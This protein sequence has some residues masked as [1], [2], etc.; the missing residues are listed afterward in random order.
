MS[1][2]AWPN[3]IFVRPFSICLLV[4]PAGLPVPGD[5]GDRLVIKTHH[6]SQKKELQGQSN[7]ID[8]NQS[9]GEQRHREPEEPGGQERRAEEP[10]QNA[11]TGLTQPSHRLGL[12]AHHSLLLIA[13][14]SSLLLSAPL[15]SSLLLSGPLQEEEWRGAERIEFEQRGAERSREEQRGVNMSRE[16][17]RGVARSS[18]E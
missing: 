16:E 6:Y 4:F 18:K 5:T 17:Q 15:H 1:K 2:L 8:G 12:C 14:H 13:P 7:E 3:D 10:Q 9:L 11:L